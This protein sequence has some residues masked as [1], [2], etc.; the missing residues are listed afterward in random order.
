M[1][2]F[3][4]YYFNDS[5]CFGHFGSL[6]LHIMSAWVGRF[7]STVSGGF[8]FVRHGSTESLDSDD[9]LWMIPIQ[10]AIAR[11][12]FRCR[13]IRLFSELSFAHCPLTLSGRWRFAK[14]WEW[15]LAST[16]FWSLKVIHSGN[17]REMM[18]VMAWWREW[19]EVLEPNDEKANSLTW[20]LVVGKGSMDWPVWLGL[21][22][23]PK[24]RLLA[25][26]A[27]HQPLFT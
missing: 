26:I 19:R 10:L 3:S 23:I 24:N 4:N 22:P 9:G 14:G 20:P 7:W 5:M 17:S 6:T 2:E 13:C 16:N 18:C 27:L 11:L 15:T 21:V 25:R 8:H 1:I 12:S